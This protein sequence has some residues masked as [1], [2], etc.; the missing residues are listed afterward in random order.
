MNLTPFKITFRLLSRNKVN[1]FINISGLSLGLA[2]A[3]LIILYVKDE[4][5][6]DL[7]H[8][9]VD[10]LFRIVQEV[11]TPDPAT[12]GKM[13]SS[14]LLSG[15]RFAAGIP[16]LESFVRV[17]NDMRDLVIGGEIKSQTVL[18]ADSNFLRY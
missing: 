10:R 4:L 16:E 2:C 18:V 1:T 11:N 13:P 6:F 5:S 17:K 14:S 8:K 7:F 3:M 15:P 12:T 9:D